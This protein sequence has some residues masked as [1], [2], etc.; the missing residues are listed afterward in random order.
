MKNLLILSVLLFSAT[1]QAFT[2]DENLPIESHNMD[3]LEHVEVLEHE[4]FESSMQKDFPSK[5]VRAYDPINKEYYQKALVGPTR[6]ATGLLKNYD[7]WRYVT[8]YN[9][10]AV[11]ERISYLPYFYEDCHD[12]SFFMA[13]W[14]ESRSIRVT[15]KSEFGFSELGLSASV[16]MSLEQGVTFSASRRVR[17]VE[18]IQA[19]H[20]PYKL[21]ETWRGVTYIQTYN[22]DTRSYGYLKPSRIESWTNSYPHEFILDNQNVGFRVVRE[23]EKTCAGY[24]AANDPVNESSLY[25]GSGRANR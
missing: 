25:M 2:V 18:G 12:N 5:R 20:F 19:K 14:D 6:R 1:T 15:F 7:Y 13:Q 22:K 10:E 23:I 8:V 11:S 3:G 17:A 4:L 21:S 24:D 16:G 9:V